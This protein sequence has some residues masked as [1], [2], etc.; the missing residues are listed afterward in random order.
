MWVATLRIFGLAFAMLARSLFPLC[1]AFPKLNLN[2]HRCLTLFNLAA[3]KAG[4]NS[5]SAISLIGC[6]RCNAS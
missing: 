5:D 4:K 1:Q 3:G 6:D 2:K